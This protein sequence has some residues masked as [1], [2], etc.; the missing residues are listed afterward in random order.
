MVHDHFATL[1]EQLFQNVKNFAVWNLAIFV[2]IICWSSSTTNTQIITMPNNSVYLRKHLIQCKWQKAYKNK[3]HKAR[4]ANNNKYK[5]SSTIIQRL[6]VTD[7]GGSVRKQGLQHEVAWQICRQGHAG[8][9]VADINVRICKENYL[10]SFHN[11]V[12]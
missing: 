9:S 8:V 5:R 11:A 4:N 6:L 12:M 10:M 7:G 1:V 3:K 2:E